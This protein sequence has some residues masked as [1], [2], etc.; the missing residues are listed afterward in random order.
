MKINKFN[1]PKNRAL[2]YKD[3]KLIRFEKGELQ[4]TPKKLTMEGGT[5][6]LNDEII[7]YEHYSLTDLKN[8]RTIIKQAINQQRFKND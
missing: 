2:Q 1:V 3:D 5:A 6:S 8:L 7:H 4:I